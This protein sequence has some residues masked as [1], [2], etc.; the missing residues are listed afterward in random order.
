MKLPPLYLMKFS[1]AN[2]F[3]TDDLLVLQAGKE[4]PLVRNW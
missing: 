1:D 2:K 3:D 4:N